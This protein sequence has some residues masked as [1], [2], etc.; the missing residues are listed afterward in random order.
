MK[1]SPGVAASC[2]LLLLM[3]QPALAQQASPWMLVAEPEQ[4]VSCDKVEHELVR[5]GAGLV[6]RMDDPGDSHD[7]DAAFQCYW[8]S[9]SGVYFYAEFAVDL[10][11]PARQLSAG[12][13]DFREEAE[14]TCRRVQWSQTVEPS[15]HF[16]LVARGMARCLTE[17]DGLAGQHF[18]MWL[19]EDDDGQQRLLTLQHS[20]YVDD[21][22]YQAAI[23][24]MI[25]FFEGGGA[26]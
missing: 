26:E 5:G 24:A 13:R 16:S 12:L 14:T 25:R 4:K 18:M 10:V 2:L 15:T 20:H 3:A 1:C 11:A 9:P 23:G 7:P 17:D 19:G 6:V 22:P 21:A 8:D